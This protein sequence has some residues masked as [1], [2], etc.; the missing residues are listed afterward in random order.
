MPLT[1]TAIRNAKPKDTPYKITDEKGLYLFINSIGKYFRFDYR[2]NNKRKTLAI[3]VYP[4]ASLAR[5]R[6]KLN[7]ARAQIANGVD[8]GELKKVAKLIREEQALNCFEA[9]AREWFT[10][11]KVSKWTASHASKVRWSR[12][13]GQCV[14]L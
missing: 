1:D 11:N 13:T 9:I 6:E 14:K 7:E 5:A 3:G 4:D 10:K 8:P 12:K 2:F